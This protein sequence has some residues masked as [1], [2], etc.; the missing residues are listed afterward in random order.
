MLG[1]A[2]LAC[3]F[4]SDTPPTMAPVP[5]PQS[6]ITPESVLQP[7]S[8]VLGPQNTIQAPVVPPAG[9]TQDASN[10]VSSTTAIISEISQIDPG[11]M[12][13]V[14]NQMINFNNRNLYS[15]YSPTQGV[16]A[17]KDWLLA[18]FA[19]IE[20]NAHPDI[21]IDYYA[22]PFPVSNGNNQISGHNVVMVMTGTDG[23]AG[24]VLVGAHYDTIHINT[25]T[26][27]FQ[28]GANDNASGVA[29]VLEIARHLSQKPRRATII[30]ALFS[31]E[32]Y[33][34]L[35]S[36]AY[37]EEV[38]LGQN[39]DVKAVVNLDTIGSPTGIRGERFDNQ[40]R[41][42]S[43]SPNESTS[44]QL[45][46]LAEIVTRIYISDMVVNVQDRIDR[47]G[48]YG[49]QESFSNVGYPA[50]RLIEQMDDPARQHNSLDTIDDIEADY[51]RRT[52][53][54]ALATMLV[55][56]DGPNP[57]A[58]FYIDIANQRLEWAPNPAAAS[59][60]VALR[61][62]GSLTFNRTIPTTDPFLVWP[63]LGSYESVAIAAVDAE[64]RLG[65]FSP[66]YYIA[67]SPI[68]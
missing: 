7:Q 68:D 60:V 43:A 59:Y 31:G 39:I 44:R 42:F 9:P 34:R 23:S 62:P 53:Q 54:V 14:I 2:I 22:D 47:P 35:G 50:I 45:A 63:E 10:N 4:T 37:V 13:N 25:G 38:L 32:E 61:Q 51:L 20:A 48:R 6:T 21:R 40:M 66:E 3:S 15:Q 5:S 12:M 36:I 18:Q 46:R 55:L 52:T 64:G 11:R 29:A 17:A 19:E 28:P 41:V 26:D 30:F 1:S 33:G 16:Y 27:N 67:P 65:M 58:D 57:P 49:D 24:V 56:V 8:T